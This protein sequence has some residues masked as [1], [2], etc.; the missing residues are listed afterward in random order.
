MCAT[1]STCRAPT[2]YGTPTSNSSESNYGLHPLTGFVRGCSALQSF[3]LSTLECFYSDTDCLSNLTVFMNETF[4]RLDTIL[5]W[6][7]PKP[8]F[9]NAST[10]RFTP[11]TSLSLLV[12]QMFV[13]QWHLTATFDR[14]YEA[15]AP[16]YCTY[17]YTTRKYSFTQVLIKN[18]LDAQWSRRRV[19]SGVASSSQMCFVFFQAKNQPTETR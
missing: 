19:A 5:P 18:G 11:N 9:Y 2:A 6:L 13:E 15:C 8:L 7:D 17:P 4:V 16:R 12:T 10:H 1:D 14:Y 3:L